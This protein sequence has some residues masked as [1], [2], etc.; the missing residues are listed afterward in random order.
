MFEASAGGAWCDAAIRNSDTPVVLGLQ[1]G[2]V[3]L[4]LLD[5]MHLHSS[6]AFRQH[7]ER[8]VVPHLAA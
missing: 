5:D 6:V 8:T 2:L 7:E 3:S 4:L 1:P